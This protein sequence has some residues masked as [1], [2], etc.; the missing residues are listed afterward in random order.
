MPE[1]QT[2]GRDEEFGIP[3]ITISPITGASGAINWGGLNKFNSASRWVIAD[4]EADELINWVPQLSA[5]QQVPG[6]GPLLAT[7]AASVIWNYSDILNGNLYTWYLCTNGHIYQVSLTGAT[8]TDLGAGFATGTNQCD[9]AIWQGAQVIINDFVAAKVYAWNGSALTTLFSSQP[10]QFVAVYGGRLW[11][12]NGLVITWTASGTY[13]SLSGDSGSF[14]IT[15][16]HCNNPVIG[17]RDLLGSLYVFGS[18]WIKTINNLVD[19]GTPAVLVFQQPT[20]NSSV[21]INTKWSLIDSGSSFYFANQYGFWTCSGTVPQKISTQLDGF[22]Q[23]LNAAS[24]FTG[25][26]TEINKKPCLLWQAQWNGDGNNTVFGLTSDGLWF[27]VIPVT[28]TG[29]G[30]VAKISGQVSSFVTNN[31]P[32]VFMTD[33]TR[34]YNLFGGS[35]TVTSTMNSK[36]WDFLSKL[37]YDLYTNFAIQFVIF[38]ATTLTISELDSAGVVSGPAQPA[39][40]RTYTYSPNQGQWINNAGAQGNWINAALTQGTWSAMTPAYFVLEQAVVPYQERAMGVN[41]TI[42]SIGAVLHSFVVSY[43]KMEA[44]KG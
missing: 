35:G 41:I 44:A 9:I 2:K 17:M 43:R 32:I 37:D 24:S 36:I 39:G 26:Y 22:F 16:G 29:T 19:V 28:G 8:V 10:E 38:S 3:P 13:N 7:L 18:N 20:L 34:I 5:F 14:A 30:S 40:P 11:M 31:E 42:S 6:P 21:S 33:G 15:D 25:A 4:S 12:S 1:A 27:R 23:N